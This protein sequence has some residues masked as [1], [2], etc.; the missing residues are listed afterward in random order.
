MWVNEGKSPLRPKWGYI[1][2]DMGSSLLVKV[3]T[4]RMVYE[5]VRPSCII[6]VWPCQQACIRRQAAHV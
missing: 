4:C 3:W 1:T 5:A 6:G 2:E